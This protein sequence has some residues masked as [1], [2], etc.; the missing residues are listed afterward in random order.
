M[1]RPYLLPLERDAIEPVV[2]TWH[3]HHPECGV[4]ALLAEADKDQLGLLQSVF[5]AQEVPLVGGIVPALIEA[6]RFV[7]RGVWL[8]PMNP[9]PPAVLQGELDAMS[10][11]AALQLYEALSSKVGAFANGPAPLLFML[12]DG[13]V[14]NIGSILTS[15]Y[16]RLGQQ[17]RYAG[18]NVGSET[19]QP[20]PCLFNQTQTIEH[21]VLALC[22]P[23][24]LHVAA[25]HGFP[26]SRQRHVQAT[27][28]LGN[29]IDKIDGRP[30]FEVYQEIIWEAY[31][32]QLTPDN[33]YEHAVHFPFGLVL[34]K[35]VLL[36]IPVGFSEEGALFCIGEIPPNSLLNVLQAPCLEDSVGIADLQAQLAAPETS[37]GQPL[38]TFY[39]AGRRMHLGAAAVEE[40]AALAS[41][42]HADPLFGALSLGEIASDEETGFPR[43]HNAAMVCLR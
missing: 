39:C 35:D 36:R 27:S 6:E 38:L 3:M 16:G 13:M 26:A 10:S 19:F 7:S 12:F 22:L 33:F 15:L 18:M 23:P 31:G 28:T 25:S 29:R 2:S 37:S 20:M 34:V 8:L 32:V 42:A 14:P 21:G 24:D 9:M 17:V 43:F 41:A 30:A 40:L 4:L 11:L 1:L 5:Q